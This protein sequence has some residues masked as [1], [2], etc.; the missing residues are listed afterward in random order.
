M[1]KSRKILIIGNGFDLAHYLPTKYEH[2]IH[3]MKVLEE[4]PPDTN[5][6]FELLYEDL[7]ANEEFIL[8]RC[9][10]LY[11]TEE[12]VMSKELVN[13]FKDSLHKNNWFQVFKNQLDSG[14]DTWI[15]FENEVEN[16]LNLIC[17]VINE[18]D[19]DDKNFLTTKDKKQAFLRAELIV[20]DMFRK[21]PA[22]FP[23]LWRFEIIEKEQNDSSKLT[24]NDEF[25]KFYHKRAVYLNTNKIFKALNSHWY[26]FISIFD[27]YI[28]F[29][30]KLTPKNPLKRPKIIDSKLDVI[31]SFNYSSTVKNFYD[32]FWIEYLHGKAGAKNKNKIVL[33]ISEL[34]SPI[35]IN[36]KAYGFVKYYQKLVNNTD[37]QFLQGNPDLTDWDEEKLISSSLGSESPIEIYVWGH[38]LDSSDSDYIKELFSFNQGRRASVNL[39]I[40][41]F[42]TPHSQL[43][44]LIS[45]MGKDI[46]EKWMKKGWLEFVESPD[47]YRL[48][49]DE[50]YEDK[51]SRF[52][53]HKPSDL[54][55]DISS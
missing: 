50:D 26:D 29:V 51:L 12:V 18:V 2:F 47:I 48:N 22:A 53:E 7:I 3:S 13:D 20:D 4:T 9:K 40:Y 44:N 15:D 45:I 35:L 5:V 41:Y 31:Y 11:K 17:S 52:C 16:T 32:D 33:G 19:K 28:Q 27:K 38:S 24:L 23:T 54:F 1:N 46:I 30:E 8:T 37:Y 6:S 39:I 34:S 55:K 21:Y 25:I 43:A 14:I 42:N 10:E 36:E 49:K